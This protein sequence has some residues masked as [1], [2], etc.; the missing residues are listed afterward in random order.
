MTHQTP[1]PSPLKGATQRACGAH[2]PAMP[3]DAPWT[4]DQ[5]LA[6]LYRHLA[7]PNS[8]R[9]A[10][11]AQVSTHDEDGELG[12]AAL[13]R[14]IDMLAARRDRRTGT[15]LET[16]AIEVKVTRQDFL[17][18]LANPLKQAVWRQTATRHAYAAPPGVIRDGEIPEGSGWLEVERIVPA[19]KDSPTVVSWAKKAPYLPDHMPGLPTSTWYTLLLRLATTEAETKGW[20]ETNPDGE[21]ALRA[22]MRV[23]ERAVEKAERAAAAADGKTQAWK[24]AYA[25][26]ASDG[27]PCRWCN[28][29]IKPLRPGKGWFGA[30]K[31]TDKTDAEACLLVEEALR[32][33]DAK[34]A[35]AAADPDMAETKVRVMRN[36]NP[37]GYD[38]DTEPWRAYLEATPRPPE[39]AP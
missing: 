28:Q 8:G 5:V 22:R 11:I 29:P 30:W 12:D 21:R 36:Y 4:E 1:P 10:P 25:A 39:P 16:L 2:D 37:R 23:L 24:T 34:T 38:Y 32:H 15:G 18:D 6:A 33:E 14:R 7:N 20:G 19:R 13:L 17:A 9:W 27:L 31:H 35:Y 26:A 3:I